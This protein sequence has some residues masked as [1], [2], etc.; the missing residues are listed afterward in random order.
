MTEVDVVPLPCSP[1]KVTQ[2]VR[3]LQPEK[4]ELYNLDTD[5]KEAENLFAHQP[6]QAARLLA[7]LEQLDPFV[8][9]PFGEGTDKE[10]LEHLRSLGYVGDE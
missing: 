3:P 2:S 9:R 1:R 4:S 6:E 7:E 5:P 10:A 8:D